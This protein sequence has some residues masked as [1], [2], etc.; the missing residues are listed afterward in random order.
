MGLKFSDAVRLSWS[1][2][3]Q[4]RK[5][6]FLIVITISV[7]FMLIVGLDL[8]F[9]GIENTVLNASTLASDG[10]IYVETGFSPAF[11]G[12]SF[13]GYV[14]S[15]AMEIVNQR[16][17]RYDGQNVG[18]VVEYTFETI[19]VKDSTS[20]GQVK[21]FTPDK[22]QVTS[23]S[24]IHDFI[25]MSLADVPEGKIPVVL[26]KDAVLSEQEQTD[27]YPV[28]EFPMS[29][30]IDLVLPGGFNVLN[31]A[32]GSATGRTDAEFFH[33]FLIVDDNSGLVTD[34]IK[35]RTEEMRAQRIE[36]L[37]AAEDE[38]VRV[39]VVEYAL[40]IFADAK[41]A[42][43]YYLR[44]A[45]EGREYGYVC[46]YSHDYY[47]KTV[48]LF[49]N[50]VSVAASFAYVEYT[51]SVIGIVLLVIAT[52]IASITLKHVIDEDVQTIA[53]YRSMGA[54]RFDVLLI[55]FCYF[56]ELCLM[57][58]LACIVIS[59]LFAGVLALIYGGELGTTLM[60]AYGL[61]T[62]PSVSFIGFNSK[63]I[64]VLLMI[65]LVAPLSLLLTLRRFSAK[66][67]A[68]KLKED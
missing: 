12:V 4:H 48:D 1:N 55:Y 68:K 38:K 43:E 40:A 42:A 46:D 5:R 36:L 37:G 10:K 33:K 14:P 22:Y 52:C 28:G 62:V 51:L 39:G 24:A 53:L 26:M 47:C 13:E 18:K 27:F 41:D 3:A 58:I 61:A 63:V 67:I 45:T 44:T 32:L 30:S 2:I 6:S 21:I 59:L 50:T 15:N 11:E 29:N 34:F 49:G 64:I 56:V 20:Y 66:H 17:E 16:I 57:S 35:E 23:D 60:R 65:I 25:N 19:E 54:S 31:W 7:L 8:M 9:Q